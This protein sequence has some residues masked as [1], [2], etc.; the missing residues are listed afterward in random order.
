MGGRYP[1]QA[2]VS[3]C[4]GVESSMLLN[5]RGYVGKLRVASVPA[6]RS[7]QASAVENE[8]TYLLPM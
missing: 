1:G 3:M 2:H 6:E 8:I 4:S 5:S 7:E